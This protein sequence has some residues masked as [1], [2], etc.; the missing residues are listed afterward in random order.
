[1]LKCEYIF[2]I[3][4][5]EAISSDSTRKLLRF[6]ITQT[7]IAVLK[8]KFIVSFIIIFGILPFPVD[9]FSA[10]LE[11]IKPVD[12]EDKVSKFWPSERRDRTGCI[13]LSLVAASWLS[14][15]CG[16]TG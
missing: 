1:M 12:V 3:K 16:V 2:Q 7:L 11:D 14:C 8:I 9:G 5:T 10:R 13:Y 15:G 4:N 6:E